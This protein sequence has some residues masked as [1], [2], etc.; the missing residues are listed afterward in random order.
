VHDELTKLIVVF[1]EAAGYIDVRLEDRTWDVGPRV[2]P[3]RQHLGWNLHQHRRPDIVCRHPHSGR[4]YV[5]DTKIAW[6]GM[7]NAERWTCVR[8]ARL[9]GGEG[10][11]EEERG[12][13]RRVGA[14]SGTIW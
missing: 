9:G 14:A 8:G 5:L 7:A 12:V 4:V 3:A 6:R 11:G 1:L 10:G 13:R 2:A